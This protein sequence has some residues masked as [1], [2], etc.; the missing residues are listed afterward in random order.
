MNLARLSSGYDLQN[1]S[2]ILCGTGLFL[3]VLNQQSAWHSGCGTNGRLETSHL[4]FA[5]QAHLA[6]S[7]CNILESS[8]STHLLQYLEVCSAPAWLSASAS[9]VSPLFK[10]NSQGKRE[11]PAHRSITCAVWW[12]TLVS[13]AVWVR[14]S[15]SSCIPPCKDLII[16]QLLLSLCISQTDFLFHETNKVNTFIS[17]PK[18]WPS[19]SSMTDTQ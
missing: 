13:E 11:C 12:V 1:D 18:A 2:S 5:Y 19:D 8:R 10:L 16:L 3:R 6:F 9:D 15:L 7:F 4:G 14:S 17:I